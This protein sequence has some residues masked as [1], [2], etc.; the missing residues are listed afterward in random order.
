MEKQLL[1]LLDYELRIHETELCEVIRPLLP[2]KA[3][4]EPGLCAVEDSDSSSAPIDVVNRTKLGTA[5]PL[6]PPEDYPKSGSSD[7]LSFTTISSANSGFNSISARS[8]H[9]SFTSC[10][11]LENAGLTDDGGSCPSSSGSELEEPVATSTS[12]SLVLKTKE[13]KFVLKPVP[14]YAYRRKN[15]MDPI[16][17]SPLCE[18][19][20]DSSFSQQAGRLLQ[21]PEGSLVNFHKKCRAAS[22]TVQEQA[23]TS[24]Y[25]SEAEA[26]TSTRVKQF[27]SSGFL[28]RMWNISIGKAT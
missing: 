17:S 6:T 2:E 5:L 22:Q 18:G 4:S 12:D 11:E 24:S 9:S 23:A 27:S 21:R 26:S 10:S 19:G 15:A 1:Y 28:S 16:T 7:S 3:Y 8:I 14:A 25:V 20:S 13:H